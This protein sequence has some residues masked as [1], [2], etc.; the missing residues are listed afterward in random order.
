MLRRMVR[1]CALLLLSGIALLLLGVG[2]SYVT[3]EMR[4]RR[5]YNIQAE[6]VPIPTGEAAIKRGGQLVTMGRCRECHGIKLAGQLYLND[7]ALGRVFAPNLTSGQN[8]IGSRYTDSDWVRAIR[9]GI[10]PDGRTLMVTPANYY[11]HLSDE[12]LGAIIAYLKQLP[13]VDREDEGAAT[14]G[15]LGRVF[16]SVTNPRD[17]LPAEKI[18]HERL[19]PPVPAPGPTIEFGSYLWQATTCGVCHEPAALAGEMEELGYTLDDFTRLLRLGNMPDGRQ[20]SN[21]LMPWSSTQFMTDEEFE[22]MWRYL[23]SEKLDGTR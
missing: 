12:D 1:G 7:P 17:W 2:L 16:V 23:Q 3:L 8:G 6:T 15:V 11:Y 22:A 18:D 14:L 21:D 9:H 4:L 10:G 5:T 19:R 20:L 13:P